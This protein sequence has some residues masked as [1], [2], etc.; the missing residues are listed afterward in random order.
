MAT[1]KN[2]IDNSEEYVEIK[3]FKDG[4]KYIDDVFVCVNGESC[5]IQRGVAVKVK[6]KFADTL[7]LSEEQQ[8]YAIQYIRE[9]STQTSEGVNE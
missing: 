9:L 1:K 5:T 3:L 2:I 8:D 4:E 6:K 7:K